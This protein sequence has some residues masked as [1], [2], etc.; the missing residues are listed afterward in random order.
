MSDYKVSDYGIFQDA[1]GTT[2][3]LN[4]KISSTKSAT[5]DV[6]NIID[7]DTIFMG[8]MADSCIEGIENLTI[9]MQ[10]RRTDF[11]AMTSYL[12]ETSNNYQ[13]GDQEAS[14]TVSLKEPY[15][16]LGSSIQETQPIPLGQTIDTSRYRSDPS[17]GFNVTSDNKT[18]NLS[19]SDVDFLYGIV[20]AESDKS[21]DDA[22]A[23]I[24]VILNRCEDEAWIH[25]FGTNPIGQAQGSGQFA[26]YSSGAYRTY[27]NGNAPSAVQQAVNDALAGVRNNEYLSFRSNGSTGYSSNMITST[28]N[29]YK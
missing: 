27:T 28:G 3:K 2:N 9:S 25:S 20:A 19:N 14:D 15:S 1:I 21:Y 18:Y 29:R 5:K 12:V 16:V 22:L 10:N 8:P 26:V 13:V 4:E 24:S 6:K 17:K 11:N 7:N 23:V